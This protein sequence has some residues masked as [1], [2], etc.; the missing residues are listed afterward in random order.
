MNRQEFRKEL[1][2]LLNKTSMDNEFDTPDYM[3]ADYIMG[4]LDSYGDTVAHRDDLRDPN[5]YRMAQADGSPY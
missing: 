3:L 4:C 5:P 2:K 1:T